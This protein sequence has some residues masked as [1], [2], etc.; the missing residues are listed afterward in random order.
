MLNVNDKTFTSL[1][2]EFS[3][4]NLVTHPG[5]ESMKS[6]KLYVGFQIDV[7]A[8]LV[9]LQHKMETE[10]SHLRKIKVF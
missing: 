10:H 3:L 4:L 5:T 8:L 9:G 2:C 1:I 6:H 7:T